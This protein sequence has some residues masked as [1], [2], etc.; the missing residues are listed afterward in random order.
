LFIF[1]KKSGQNE[2]KKRVGFIFRQK[3]QR[4]LAKDDIFPKEKRQK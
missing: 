1:D 2:K 4:T 3:R